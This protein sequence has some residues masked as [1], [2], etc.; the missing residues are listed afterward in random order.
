MTNSVKAQEKKSWFGKVLTSI[1]VAGNRLP[2]PVTLFVIFCSAIILISWRASSSGIS[3]IHPASGETVTVVNL[4]SREGMTRILTGFVSNFQSFPPLG[5]VLVVM[6]GAGVAEKSGLMQT[7]MKNSISKVPANLVTATI[8]LVGILANA[9]GDAGFIVLPPLAAVI[10]L[11]IGRHPVVGIFAAYAGVA[12]GFAANLMINMADIL[13]ASFTIPAAQVIDANYQGTPAMNWYFIMAS[14]LFLVAAAVF[15]TERIIAPRFGAY[16][17]VLEE[18]T[19]A[20]ISL[21]E[22][23]ALKWAGAS[24]LFLIIVLISLSV[25]ENAF[26]KDPETGSIL[27]ASS[28]LMKGLVP[29]VTLIFLAPGLVYGKITGSIKNDKE[30]VTMMGDSMRDMGPYIILAFVASQ[31]LAYF[32]WSNIGVIMSVKGA[33]F[34]K[35]AGFTGIGLII[36]F[37]IFSSFINIFIGSASAKWAIMAPIFV[38]MF[39]LLG[40]NP[41]LTQMAYRI[42]DSLTNPLSPLFPYFPILL[43]FARKYDK[44]AGIGTM[45]ANMLPYSIVF[46]IVWTI[47]LVIFMIFNIPLGPDAGIYYTM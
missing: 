43:A 3:I 47:L 28:P 29:I 34:L 36:G 13:A 37:I 38:P 24:V 39:L 19:K 42:G 21:Q 45:I 40:Y 31:F 20:E 10:F 22:R 26:M 23:K 27:A 18:A 44:K 32:N 9:A 35:N 6:I 12:G 8:V 5:L 16:E 33:E 41:A 14:T 15:V 30:A 1:E 46:A 11:S 7:A 2:D 17:G 25:G 4:M